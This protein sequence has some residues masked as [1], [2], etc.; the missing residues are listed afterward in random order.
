MSQLIDWTDKYLVGLEEIDSQHKRKIR[1]VNNILTACYRHQPK[2]QII[3]YMKELVKYAEWHF[4]T[5][6]SLMELYNYPLMNEHKEEHTNL[7][8]SLLDCQKNY[9]TS[10]IPFQK[11]YE[12][13]FAWFGGHAFSSDRELSSF[14]SKE[15]P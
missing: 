5:E 8:N 15:L 14:L 12:F 4:K 3:V 10:I 1:L 9:N 7:I 11:M 2:E 6:E 13:Y